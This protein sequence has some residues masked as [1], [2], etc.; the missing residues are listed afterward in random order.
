M[1]FTKEV[2]LTIDQ[3]CKNIIRDLEKLLYYGHEFKN[4]K[5][6]ANNVLILEIE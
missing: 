5:L 3:A 2:H 4:N 1:S 6:Y